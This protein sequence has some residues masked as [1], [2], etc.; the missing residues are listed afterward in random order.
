ME[1]DLDPDL[2][3]WQSA[4]RSRPTKH[5]NR[6]F[7]PQIL[8][9]FLQSGIPDC[10]SWLDSQRLTKAKCPKNIRDKLYETDLFWGVVFDL[11]FGRKSPPKHFHFYCRDVRKS[12]YVSYPQEIDNWPALLGKTR[13]LLDASR[14]FRQIRREFQQL[15]PR[16]LGNLDLSGKLELIYTLRQNVI[17]FQAPGLD[18]LTRLIRLKKEQL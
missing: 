13:E 16:P 17:Q 5:A 1:I 2:R 14:D 10:L 4:G 7:D 18:L 6:A 8:V 12:G 15:L 3:L 9:E 11:Q